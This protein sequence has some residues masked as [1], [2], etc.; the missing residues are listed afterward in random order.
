MDLEKIEEGVKL[1]IEGIGENP[2]R[3]GILETPQRV[4]RMYE[5]ILCGM[6]IEPASVVQKKFSENHD[7]MIIVK[8]IPLYSICEHHLMP[9]L[10]KAH[11]AYIPGHDGQITG[12]SKLA[13][14]VDV[15]SKR[16][17]V[18]ERLT[19]TIADSL[20]DALNPSGVLVIVEA[21]H[22]CMSMRGIKKPGAL[23]ITSA[24]RGLFL[25]NSASRAEAMALIGNRQ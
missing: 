3:E 14:V 6:N 1:I 7:E 4:A 20:V 19:T 15:L 18:Q 13:R 21:E 2:E 24:V 5:E 12:I 25:K 10:G 23:T 22:L 16:L 17:Q 9:F 8:D 11:V